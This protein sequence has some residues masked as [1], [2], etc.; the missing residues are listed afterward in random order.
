ML[1]ADGAFGRDDPLI[2]PLSRELE[3][4]LTPEEIVRL[5][6]HQHWIVLWR[7]AAWLAAALAV[8]GIMLTD[9]R[10]PLPVLILVLV[11]AGY[12]AWCAMERRLNT[13]VATTNRVMRVEGLLNRSVPMMKLNKVTD[14]R[15]DRP[16]LGRFFGYGTIT[17]E[18]A[19]QDQ[20]IRELRY[21]PFP[22][23]VYRRLNSTI[24][25]EAPTDEDDEPPQPSPASRIAAAGGRGARSVTRAA[26][27]QAGRARGGSNS[28]SGPRVYYGTPEA[29]RLLRA[30]R[31]PVQ[32]AR[33]R[34]SPDDTDEIPVYRRG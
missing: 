30:Q 9:D 32:P 14:M 20:S 29:D 34:S 16:L 23:Q 3:R 33:R 28:D 1:G 21:A 17:I 15:L 4:N 7:P 13:F 25:D 24:F 2:A 10:L 31:T 6:V 18:S 8:L 27:R 22:T 11:A 26:Q 12:F 5:N 19:G